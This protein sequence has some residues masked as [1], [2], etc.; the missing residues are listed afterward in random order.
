MIRFCGLTSQVFHLL[1]C[2]QNGITEANYRISS[3]MTCFV[4]RVTFILLRPGT[5]INTF[6]V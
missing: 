3:L 2:L 4:A 5:N 6:Y 1:K